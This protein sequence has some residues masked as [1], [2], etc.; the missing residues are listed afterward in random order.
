M[1]FH[2]FRS[3]LHLLPCTHNFRPDHCLSLPPSCPDV[4]SPA[5]ASTSN[6]S[7]LHGSRS[8][9]QPG[10][11]FGS[12]RKYLSR[13][14]WWYF[15]NLN[16]VPYSVRIARTRTEE[17]GLFQR[18]YEAYRDLDPSNLPKNLPEYFGRRL[19]G[20]EDDM[21][22]EVVEAVKESLATIG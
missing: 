7:I 20:L 21:C 6:I 15:I 8:V 14:A 16:F 5:A 12:V 18:L 1:I 13:T 19:E 9:C 4:A 2:H 22:G 11:P 3:D 10:W 17:Q